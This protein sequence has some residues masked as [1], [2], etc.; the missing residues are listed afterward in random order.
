M[1]TKGQIM[2]VTGASS[3]IGLITVRELAARG[4]TV[5]LVCRD[6]ARGQAA[7]AEVEK[8]A[9]GDAPV[10]MLADLASQVSIR[11]LADQVRRRFDRLDVLVSNAGAIY[12]R[13]QVT[14]DGFEET[15][16]TNHLAPF[17][18]T[19]LLRDRLEA[20]PAGRVVVVSSVAH[21]RAKLDF[22]DLQAERKYEAMKVYGRSKLANVLF[23]YE[24]ARRLAGT[25][26]T[27]NCLHPGVIATNFG[28]NTPG[29]FNIGI[30]IAAPFM[31]SPEKGAQT[32]I[33]LA[34]SPEVAGVTGKYF[35]KS[36]EARSSAISRDPEVAA[37]LWAASATMVGIA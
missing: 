34:S 18:L 7:L 20:A 24:L 37:K 16:A 32:Q 23:T 25:R 30:R 1:S 33:Y 6:Q 3:G 19:H 22:D 31:M 14:V 9:T 13:R 26:V 17:L 11:A 8:A 5:V 21:Q 4:A 28:R 2:L 27:A 15:F 35:V 29:L 36:H 10:L 12:T